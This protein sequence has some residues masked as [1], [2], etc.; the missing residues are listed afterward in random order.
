[1]RILIHACCA[2]CLLYPYNVLSR[3]F[4]EIYVLWYNPNIHPYREYLKRK[5]ALLNFSEL[6][7]IKVI[8]LD[9]YDIV[10]FT[11]NV[12]FRESKRCYFCYSLRLERVASVAKKGNFDFFTTTLLYSK[13]QKHELIVKIAE[14]V[15]A[16]KGVKFYYRDFR[17]GW[18]EG[19]EESKSL[20]L[21]RQDYCGCIY[22]EAERFGF[23][24]GG[25]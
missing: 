10:N 7:G 20:G 6:K 5:E 3:E 16:T 25:D 19:I 12:A 1:M 9:E 11:R 13:H 22:S 17:E 24:I 18:K 15:A 2:N 8:Y 14:S 4:D 21:Y 23:K